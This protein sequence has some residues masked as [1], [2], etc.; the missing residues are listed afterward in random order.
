MIKSDFAIRLQPYVNRMQKAQVE[1]GSDEEQQKTCLD[2][3]TRDIRQ[4]F[5][6]AQVPDILQAV[7]QIDT[8]VNIQIADSAIHDKFVVTSKRLCAEVERLQKDLQQGL[9]ELQASLA[10]TK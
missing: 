4:A 6:I 5:G 2:V 9:E 7:A 1:L 10:Q 3:L 8:S